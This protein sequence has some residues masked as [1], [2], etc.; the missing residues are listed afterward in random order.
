[1]ELKVWAKTIL[2]VQKYL[3]RVTYAIDSMIYKEALGSAY[4]S[5]KNLTKQSALSV[6]E[7]IINLSDRK[8][9]LINLNV[10]CVKALKGIDRISAKLLILKHIENRTSSE[11]A[12]ILDISDRTYFRKLNKAYD[13]IGTWLEDNGFNSEYFHKN[14]GNEGWIMEAYY[15]NS[16]EFFENS[17]QNKNIVCF[18][19]D[20]LRGVIKSI[21]R[22]AGYS[23]YS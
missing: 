3:E 12:Q 9:N 16:K 23:S 11:I 4:V 19:G 7:S 18:D 22:P 2:T 8:V 15:Q 1:M 17:K 21:A 14:F 10:I 13:N 5:S 20:F 6:S